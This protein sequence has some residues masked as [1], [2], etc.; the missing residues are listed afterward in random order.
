VFERE[1]TC[2]S[3]GARFACAGLWFCWCRNVS[4]TAQARKDLGERYTGC[5]CRSCLEA[6]AKG[7]GE[8][9][10]EKQALHH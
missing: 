1:K 7:V 4:L 2:P 5:L 10:E 9:A 3:C 6:H 8:M